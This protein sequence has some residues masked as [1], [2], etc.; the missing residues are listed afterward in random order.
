M[1]VHP[2][3]QLDISHGGLWDVEDCGMSILKRYLVS[4]A[5][6]KATF[7]I[8]VGGVLYAKSDG[9]TAMM[10]DDDWDHDMGKVVL[11]QLGREVGSWLTVRISQWPESAWM[12]ARDADY[13]ARRT[14]DPFELYPFVTNVLPGMYPD[15]SFLFTKVALFG[16]SVEKIL[17]HD[18]I[19]QLSEEEEREEQ[20]FMEFYTK[21][22]Q[23]FREAGNSDIGKPFDER[24]NAV[25]GIIHV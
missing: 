18:D 9:A 16:S 13:A 17:K 11:F 15:A 20:K 19:G 25:Y 6:P 14:N 2:S 3:T 8:Y 21:I 7:Q 24:V 12:V 22:L 1:A 4:M 23:C 5:V 10:A